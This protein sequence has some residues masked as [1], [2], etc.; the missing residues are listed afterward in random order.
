MGWF[1]R[2]IYF[3]FQ[4]SHALTLS[5]SHFFPAAPR[6]RSPSAFLSL[7]PG[8]PGDFSHPLTLSRLTSP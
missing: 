8:D 4:H 3:Y 7:A 1:D 5:R 2:K 6:V